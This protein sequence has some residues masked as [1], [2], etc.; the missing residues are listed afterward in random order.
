MSWCSAKWLGSR[1]AYKDFLDALGCLTV[2]DGTLLGVLQ[3]KQEDGIEHPQH[4]AFINMVG[5][6]IA[7]NLAHFHDQMPRGFRGQ[8]LF[9]LSQLYDG[10][11]GQMNEVVDGWSLYGDMLIGHQAVTM[12]IIG[13]GDDGDG[14]AW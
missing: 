1:R 6:Q 12:E 2:C 14:E 3:I 9:R 11:V 5:M 8:G 10:H 13:G 4:L 7:D